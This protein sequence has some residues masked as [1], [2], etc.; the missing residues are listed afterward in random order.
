[1]HGNIHAI[2]KLGRLYLESV[3]L[4]CCIFN[5]RTYIAHP[6]MD[7]LDNYFS[8]ANDESGCCRV[9]LNDTTK[10]CPSDVARM[11]YKNSIYL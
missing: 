5:F 3:F 6:P 2:I 4:K 1:M 9:Y 7:W 11:Y 8:W 10:F